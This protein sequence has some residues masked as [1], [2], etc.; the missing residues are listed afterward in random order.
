VITDKA[1]AFAF[2]REKF[3]GNLPRRIAAMRAAIE[4]TAEEPLE[5]QFHSLAGI[6]GT[7]GFH[8]ITLLAKAGEAACGAGRRSEVLLAIVNAIETVGGAAG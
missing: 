1:A 6:G 2:L 3:L 5:L 4:G 8:D 7:Y